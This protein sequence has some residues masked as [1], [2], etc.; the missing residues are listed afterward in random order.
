MRVLR[1]YYESTDRSLKTLELSFE[2]HAD[3][4]AF[5]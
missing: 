1:A 4:Q 5:F 2:N 3:S